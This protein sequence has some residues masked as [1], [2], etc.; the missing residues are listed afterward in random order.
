M[1]GIQEA[2]LRPQAGRLHAA[3]AQSHAPRRARARGGASP[4]SGLPCHGRAR[5]WASGP[6]GDEEK[7]ARWASSLDGPKGDEEKNEMLGA[8]KPS[9]VI[10]QAPPSA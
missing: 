3:K 9:P 6:K 1:I 4:A 5:G 7:D 2:Q 10:S 8:C